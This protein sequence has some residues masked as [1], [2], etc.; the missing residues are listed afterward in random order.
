MPAINVRIEAV[1]YTPGY[2]PVNVQYS[3]EAGPLAK[4]NTLFTTQTALGGEWSD[5]A[6][7]AALLQYLDENGISAVITNP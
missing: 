2:E 5:A 6:V 3:A 1:Q 4:T 7:R